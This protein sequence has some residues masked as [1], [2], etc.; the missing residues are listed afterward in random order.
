MLS[1]L[2]P[3]NRYAEKENWLV[4]TTVE[5]GVTIGA[6]STIVCGVRLGSYSF[7]AAG[8]V[9]TA[10]VEPLAL[11]VGAPARKRGYVC[12][13]GRLLGRSLPVDRCDQCDATIDFLH[14]NL[15][16]KD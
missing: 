15:A 14:E 6:N 2:C 3:A 13:C 9:V 11:M 8:A 12:R 5:K 4:E 16:L 1:L 7:I 10:D